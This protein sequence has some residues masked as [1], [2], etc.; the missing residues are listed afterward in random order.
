MLCLVNTVKEKK[1]YDTIPN[2]KQQTLKIVYISFLKY[3]A[4]DRKLKKNNKNKK[5][6]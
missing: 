3:G 1:N 6:V 2:S 5:K 4:L